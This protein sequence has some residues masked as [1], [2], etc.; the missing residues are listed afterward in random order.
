MP[1]IRVAQQARPAP[2]EPPAQ[3][4]AFPKDHHLVVTTQQNVLSWDARGL[5]RAFTSGSGGIHAA[6][7]A[8]DGSNLL[9]IADSQVVLLHDTNRGMEKSYRLKGTDGQIRLL[10]YS[11]DSKSLF[12]T[13][14]LQNAVQSYSLRRS[15]LLE[16]AH[17]HPSPPTVLAT[18]NTSHLLLSASENPPTIYLQNLTLRTPPVLIQPRASSSAAVTA[19]FHPERPN[20]FLIAFKDGT[21]AAY[22][23][24]RILGKSA[25]GGQGGE[26]GH[27]NDLHTSI[28]TVSIGSVAVGITGAAFLPGHRSRAVS[29]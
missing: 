27:F 24:T 3:R 13:T 10:E 8:K 9:A 1:P 25:R 26:I 18:S 21:L 12:F 28:G 5:T 15:C 6:K 11:D 4:F 23:A 7:E 14:T 22:D 17:T 16:P 19:S 2:A 20:V 29:V